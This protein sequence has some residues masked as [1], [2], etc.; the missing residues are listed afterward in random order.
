[1]RVQ[2]IGMPGS[3]KST[4]A[5]NLA[6]HFGA[7]YIPEVY[8]GNPFLAN[9]WELIQTAQMGDCPPELVYNQH[10][11]ISQYAKSLGDHRTHIVRDAGAQ[12]GVCYTAAMASMGLIR[13]DVWKY[14]RSTYYSLFMPHEVTIYLSTTP[15]SLL[16][17]G[18][19]RGREFEKQTNSAAITTFMRRAIEFLEDELV[20]DMRAMYPTNLIVHRIDPDNTEYE[21]FQRV[22]GH[23]QRR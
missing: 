15:D 16:I 13:E 7:Q 9:A 19:S 6:E 10:W 3:G 17:R 1:M 22:L 5:K 23:L 18:Q 11:F 4:L 20:P 2:V 8:E 12:M 21:T 14:M